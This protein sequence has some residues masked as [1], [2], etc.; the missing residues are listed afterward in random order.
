MQIRAQLPCPVILP[1]HR[2]RDK[3]RGF[4]RAYAPVLE[5]VGIDQGTFLDFLR[6]FKKACEADGW[7]QAVNLAAFG[8]GFVPNP[9][10]M[11]VSTAVQFAVGVAME[12]Q[13]LSRYTFLG[14]CVR[15]K[16]K[17]ELEQIRSS[18]V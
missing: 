4:V 6:T 5:D 15:M 13:R 18:I 17:N 10:A 12:V 2:P 14:T 7:L 3:K 9:I 16:A 1:Q 11:G 8:A